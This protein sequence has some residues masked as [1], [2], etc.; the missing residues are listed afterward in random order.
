MERNLY[1]ER[2]LITAIKSGDDKQQNGALRQLYMDKVITLKIKDFIQ[3]Y[4]TKHDA[5]DIMQEGILLMRRLI[6]EDKFSG[7][8]KVRTFLIGICRNLIR[9]DLKKVTR[10]DL[11][12]DFTAID[13][14][15]LVEN[16]DDYLFLEE[17]TATETKRDNILKTLL[18]QLTEK[19]RESLKLKYYKDK[20]MVQ[21]AEAR[22]L[23]N[24][25]QAKKAVDRCRQRLRDLIQQEPQL[26]D[27][28][29]GTL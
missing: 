23:K 21:I 29:K 2:Q 3:H 10:V 16:I 25:N 1:D 6:Q 4:G 20:T 24:A 26:A 11:K 14:D 9:G 28:L 13:N 8:S 19:C 5:D 22:Q 18:E 27:F 15:N 17:Q 7:N 12:G